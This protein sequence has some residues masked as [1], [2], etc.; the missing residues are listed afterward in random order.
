MSSGGH[1]GD[2]LGVVG[3][4]G[5]EPRQCSVFLLTSAP[6]MTPSHSK[7]GRFESHH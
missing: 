3:G 2:V 4:A 6:L 1:I 5:G 7:V